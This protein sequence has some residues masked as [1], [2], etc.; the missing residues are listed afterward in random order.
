MIIAL[1]RGIIVDPMNLPENFEQLVQEVFRD[2]T[3]ETAPEYRYQDKLKFIDDFRAKVDRKDPEREVIDLIKGQVD[4]QL[5]EDGTFPDAED[6]WSLEFMVDCFTK[7][8]RKAQLYGHYRG[9]RKQEEAV[10]MMLYRV[11]KAVMDYE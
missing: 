10:M 3:Y 1:S 4:W 2:Y 9:T 11:I 5:S 6:F 7:G 8:L